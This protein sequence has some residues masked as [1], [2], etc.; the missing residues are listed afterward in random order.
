[1]KNVLREQQLIE[2]HYNEN[3]NTKVYKALDNMQKPIFYKQTVKTLEQKLIER[4][5][6][7]FSDVFEF[8]TLVIQDTDQMDHT[9]TKQEEFFIIDSQDNII[10]YF[11]SRDEFQIINRDNV[12]ESA[13][14]VNVIAL[15]MISYFA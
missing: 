12:K 5:K 2:C 13:Q 6:F 4:T 15:R 11:W 1:M 9:F 10:D 14:N 3:L 7:I 8:Q